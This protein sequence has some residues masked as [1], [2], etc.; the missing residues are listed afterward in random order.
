MSRST[1]SACSMTSMPGSSRTRSSAAMRA[2]QISVPV[3]SPPACRMRSRWWPPSRVSESP[4]V[5]P[6]SNSAPSAMRS[7]T[8]SVPSRTSASTASTSQRPTPATR[9]SWM[10]SAGLSSGDMTAAMPPCAQAVD[11]SSSTVFVTSRT[12]STRRRSRSAVV[13]PAMPEP[14]TMTSAVVVQP[15]AGARSR[16]GTV[17]SGS[18]LCGIRW[19]LSPGTRAGAGTGRAGTRGGAR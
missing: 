14:T 3:A 10:C 1:T 4:P 6:R 18:P 17:T 19:P 2:R 5:S 16:R 13:S 9:V 7:Q 15:G 8:A 12:R 11:P